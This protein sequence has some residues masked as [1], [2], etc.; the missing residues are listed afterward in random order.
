MRAKNILPPNLPHIAYVLL[1]YPL[2]T[3][4]FI[5]REVEG[6]RKYLPLKVYT[7]YGENLRHCSREMI[8][9][10]GKAKT[11]GSRAL[12]E[13][14]WGLCREAGV[15]PRRGWNLFRRS[16]IHKWTD[17]ETFGENLWAFSTGLLLGRQFVE[18]G[19]DMVYSP[20]PRGA[21]TAAWV[22]ATIADLPFAMAARGDNL[23]PADP[24]L[25]DKFKGACFVR[26]NNMA[27]KKRIEE[28]DKGQAKGKTVMIY[29]SMTLASP[30]HTP[31]AFTTPEIRILSLGRFDVTKGFDVLLKACAILKA[32]KIK[33]R[34]TLA[35]GGGKVMG[36]GHLEESLK[37]MRSELDL[38]DV[39][40][41]PG[42][43]SHDEL[44]D[45]LLNHDIFA[46]PCIVHSS[47]RRDGIPNTVIEAMAYGLP[48]VGT[49]VESL[50]E[51][52]RNGETG[53]V[54]EQNNPQALADAIQ[55]LAKNTG[56]ASKMGRNGALLARN[57][58]DADKNTKKFADIFREKYDS[59]TEAEKCAV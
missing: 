49:D 59:I 26:T 44:P 7:L 17:L 6:L 18:D 30:E 22:G 50:T 24:D 38:E 47:G 21:T 56:T 8:A 31:P 2:F 58:F 57:I 10:A 39:V 54:V 12:P 36:L 35:G 11:Y 45:I 34:L 20:W 23:E 55:W 1:W 27:D 32:R 19:I 5:F 42:L 40:D 53:L 33:F 46:A 4:P 41:M 13:I 29:N 51:I 14:I 3:Q 15:N 37:K 52:V 43:I 9:S 48:I 28:F 25:G 16:L